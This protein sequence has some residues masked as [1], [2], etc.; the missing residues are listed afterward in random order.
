MSEMKYQ[1]KMYRAR[2][3]PLEVAPKGFMN[4]LNTTYDQRTRQK[5][6]ESKLSYSGGEV[7]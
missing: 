5:L 1:L 6:G 7:L 2:Y 4:K 3:G